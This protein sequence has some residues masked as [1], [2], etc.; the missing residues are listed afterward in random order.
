VA[1][2]A[3]VTNHHVIDGCSR[4]RVN[5]TA[6]QMRGSDARSDLALWRVTLLGPS[7]SSRAQRAAVGESVAVAG[8]PLR[9]LLSGFNM[10]PSNLSSL[11]GKNQFSKRNRLAASVWALF[12]ANHSAVYPFLVFKDGSAPALRR[13]FMHS[14]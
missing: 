6:A 11:S 5:G 9:G 4:L 10:T 1:R 3:V 13:T 12:S 8:Y 7:A 14:I 2:G